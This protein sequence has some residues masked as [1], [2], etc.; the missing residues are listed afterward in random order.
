[1]QLSRFFPLSAAALLLSFTAA[2]APPSDAKIEPK[3]LT[4]LASDEE[5]VAPFFVVFGEQPNLAAA[6]AIRNRVDRGRFVVESLKD[7][8]NRSQSGVRGFLQGRKIA[9]TP[10]WVENKIYVPQGTLELARSLSQRPEVVAIISETIYQVPQPQVTGT[11]IQST[12]WGVAKIRANQV[13]PSTTGAGTVVANIDTGV[14]YNHPALVNQY[15]GNSGGGVFTHA[16]NWYDPTGTYP[17]APGDNNGHGTHTMGTMVGNDGAGN[18]IGVAPGAKWIACK[19]CSTSSCGSSQLISCAQWVMDPKGNGDASAQPDVVNNSWGGGSGNTW[20]QTYIQNW[21]AA[22]IFP[23]FSAGNSG[24]SCATAN[25]PG[26]NPTAFASGATDSADSIA[27]FSSR[28]PSA[29]GGSIKPNVS[30]PGVS[31]R[32]SVPTNSYAYYSGTSMASPHTAGTV[33]LLWAAAAGY[34]GNVSGTEQLLQSTAT[35][36]QTAENC[37][38]TAG[39]VPNDTYGYGRID[40]LSAVNGA[41]TPPNQPPVV[42]I[43]SPAS[44]SQQSC[45][46]SPIPF[47]GTATDPEDGNIGGKIVWTESGVQYGPGSS[48]SIPF[49]CPTTSAGAPHTVYAS[50]TDSG[51]ATSSTSITITIYNP[52]IPAAPTN[53]SASVS[54]KTV[55]LKWSYSTTQTYTGFRVERKLKNGGTWGLALETGA[56]VMAATDTPGNGNWQYRVSAEN[57]TYLSAP[58][59][60]VSARVR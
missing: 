43:T 52:A 41:G 26:D 32:S 33:A 54:G 12:E 37:G 49:T 53:L 44:G 4:A 14:Q 58:S 46:A 28:G 11:T 47:T 31:I 55:S 7:I 17:T 20:Y 34:R 19:G 50:V 22:G 39:Q 25:S 35:R 36:I 8:A 5:A 51:G 27:S 42:Q 15:R 21:R 29:L 56:G 40:A 13:W 16:G 60:I 2:A 59:N 3:L 45:T 30:A 1:M 38:N 18:Q 6:Y 48:V 10:F 57:G 9:F 24:P 23:A